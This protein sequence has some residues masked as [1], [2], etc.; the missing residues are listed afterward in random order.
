ME[1]PT[2]IRVSLSDVKVIMV[3]MHILVVKLLCQVVMRQ[4]VVLKY[5]L[6]G[7]CG[8]LWPCPIV[9]CIKCHRFPTFRLWCCL[10]G[11]EPPPPPRRDCRGPGCVLSQGAILDTIVISC[12]TVADTMCE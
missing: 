6:S 8:H 9:P 11:T 1:K 2:F 5:L 7:P 12:A 3:I 10:P 4:I